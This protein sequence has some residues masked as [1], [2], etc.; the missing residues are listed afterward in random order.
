MIPSAFDYRRAT[1]LDEALKLLESSSGE[2]KVVAGGHSLLPLMK[3]RLAAP[4]ALIDIARI[5]ELAGIRLEDGYLTIGATTVYR[6]IVQSDLVARYFPL[7]KE[8]VSQIG[9][10]QV[11]NR[12]TIG[13]SLSHADPSADLPAVMLALDAEVEVAGPRG[14]DIRSIHDFLVG[15]LMTTLDSMEL[16]I[17]IRLPLLPEN[18]RTGYLKYP[19]PAS[20]YAVVGVASVLTMGASGIVEDAR[21]GVTGVASVPFRA[22]QSEAALTGQSFTPEVIERAAKLSPEDAVIMGDVFM[23]EDYR[24]QICRVYVERALK[25]LA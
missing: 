20:G 23:S 1:T 25:R 6:D 7:L 21:I 15:P 3:M 9:D 13:G 19:H 5:P 16:L 14:M 10:L 2:T 12:G 24:Q 17:R 18:S 22:R 11:R 4:Q 8:A